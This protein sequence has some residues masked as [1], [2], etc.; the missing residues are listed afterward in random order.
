MPSDKEYSWF[1]FYFKDWE[2][3]KIL[4]SCGI[5]AK[6]LLMDLICAAQSGN[7]VGT[8]TN[9]SGRA[10]SD[11][12][13][14]KSS[15]ETPYNFYKAL[16]I[17]LSEERI[18]R[19][20]S[21][22]IVIPQVVEY[23][24]NLLK[25]QEF[26]RK[27]YEVKKAKTLKGGLKGGLKTDK[28]RED[29]IRE[30]TICPEPQA[31]T[32]P[33]SKIIG[34]FPCSGEPKEFKLSQKKLTEYHKLYGEQIDVVVEAKKAKQWLVDNPTRRKTHRGMTR[35]LNGWFNTAINS[36]RGAKPKSKQKCIEKSQK[37][38]IEAHKIR[39]I[40]DY[41]DLN[42]SQI[43]K[44]IC[45]IYDSGFAEKEIPELVEEMRSQQAARRDTGKITEVSDIVS[46]AVDGIQCTG[47]MEI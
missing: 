7:P 41:P 35:F 12:K 2:R 27:G 14:R 13:I 1:K 11:E 17:L 31:A 47:D 45:L 3:N 30:E 10:I 34:I 6:G 21:G 32:E 28:I 39:L 8:V 22:I 25:Q 42:N 44:L 23:H 26:G 37:Q 16:N 38:V 40:K 33:Q 24:A 36:G 5:A 29:K 4:Q 46:G 15:Q 19:Q 43:D 9:S 18:F 20:E